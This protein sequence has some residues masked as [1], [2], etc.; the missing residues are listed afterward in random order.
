MQDFDDFVDKAIYYRNILK[1]I[2]SARTHAAI[3]Q[4]VG[5][6]SGFLSVTE[7]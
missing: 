6:N 4:S 7:S 3:N 1:R 5:R 2:G